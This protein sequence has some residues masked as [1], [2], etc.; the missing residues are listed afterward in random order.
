MERGKLYSSYP[1]NFYNLQVVVAVDQNNKPVYSFNK[2]FVD[3]TPKPVSI[4][5]FDDVDRWY[6]D[7]MLYYCEQY[8]FA[9]YCATALCGVSKDQLTKGLPLTRAIMNFHVMY[10]TKKILVQMEARTFGDQ[11]FDPHN[12]PY[13]K[14]EYQKIL[15][16]FGAKMDDIPQIDQPAKGLGFIRL[17]YGPSA[18][19]WSLQKQLE[20]Y[21]G[22]H[23]AYPKFSSTGQDNVYMN[24]QKKGV[25]HFGSD[26]Q[27]PP[28][29]SSVGT[30]M[31]S[32]TQD[33][34]DYNRVV[35]DHSSAFTNP[36][37]VRLNDSIRAYVYCLLGAQVQARQAGSSL[38]SQK[39]FLTLVNDLIVKKQSL[40]ESIKN[41]EDALSKTRGVIDYVIAKRLY[42]LPSDM[43]LNELGQSVAGFNDEL[44]V[45]QAFDGVGVKPKPP[46]LKSKPKLAVAKPPPPKSKPKLTA[47]KPPPPKPMLTT[48]PSK[49]SSSK[50]VLPTVT[51]ASAERDIHEGEKLLISSS[52]VGA[53]IGY[54]LLF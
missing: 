5:S 47:A 18:K 35:P 24:V 39:Q 34:F 44:K 33:H 42:M 17:S 32:V 43:N 14:T 8:K 49:L 20:Y 9:L 22:T 27:F 16:E 46:P 15:N 1:I 52:I 40:E 37:I 30:K 36:G 28:W 48:P 21:G 53:G 13:N 31:D 38:E 41:F 11:D 7:N 3:I 4:K 29:N 26:Y 23:H 19:L 6:N 51:T 54:Y 45:A 10:Q 25:A 2:K 50:S 12:N